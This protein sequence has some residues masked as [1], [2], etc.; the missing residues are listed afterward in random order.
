MGQSRKILEECFD[1][2]RRSASA[3]RTP[4]S[5]TAGGRLL[6]ERSIRRKLKRVR[7]GGGRTRVWVFQFSRF[8]LGNHQPRVG[9]NEG[10]KGK[11]INGGEKKTEEETPSNG[12]EKY[13]Y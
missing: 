10:R 12:E 6:K 1:P 13:I 5:P 2:K 11:S 4:T 9:N 7:G 8:L 3:M